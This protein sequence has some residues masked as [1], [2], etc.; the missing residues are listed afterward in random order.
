MKS[1]VQKTGDS[2]S[3]D[4]R[5]QCSV[6]VVI[7]TEEAAHV[8]VLF[9]LLLSFFLGG[10]S[11]RSRTTGGG[12]RPRAHRGKLGHAFGDNLVEGLAGHLL[13]QK[14]DLVRIGFDATV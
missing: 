3:F 2:D 14:L 13:H 1:F 7:S 12:S 8:D 5:R 6:V 4:W 11:G 9:L 10:L